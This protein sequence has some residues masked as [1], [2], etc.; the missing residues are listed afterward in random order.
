MNEALEILYQ[1]YFAFI[2]WIFNTAN[3][4]PGVSI[5]WIGITVFIFSVMINSIIN[6]ARAGSS[7]SYTSHMSVQEI[8]ARN[9]NRRINY[10]R[11]H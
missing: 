1:I 7:Y 5:G 3:I 9:T 8:Q 2:D 4:V 11:R 6:I 10:D